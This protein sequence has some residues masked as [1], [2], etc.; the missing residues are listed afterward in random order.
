MNETTRSP[1]LFSIITAV[2]NTAPYLSEAVE[3]IV[4]QDIGFEKS[5]EL[6]LI[7]DGSTDHSGAICDA[8]KEKYPNNIKVVHKKNEGAASARNTGI[9]LA[10]GQYVNF[11]D[12]DD[13]LS[14]DTLSEVYRYFSK[15]DNEID[16]VSVPIYF[17][18]KKDIP[19]R[20]NYKYN[21]SQNLM[22][23]LWKQ[24]SYVQMHASSSFF[25]RE[26]LT[27]D[28]FDSSLRYAEDAKA[29]M[30]LLLQKSR[31][32]IVPRGRYF[33]RF[34]NAMDS[35]LNGSKQHK[36]WYI[37]CLKHFILWTIQE[38]KQAFGFIPKFVQYTL[39]YD[40]QSRFRMEEL[41]AGVLNPKEE[42][43]FLSLLNEALFY[44][45]DHIILEQKNL[46]KE[47][48]DYIIGI[49]HASGTGIFEYFNEDARIRYKDTVTFSLS[50]YV[51]KLQSLDFRDG[52]V[53]IC[54]SVKLN[55]KFPAPEK[56]YVRMISDRN[57]NI[58][59]FLCSCENKPEKR[60]CFL[61]TELA[62]FKNFQVT[63]PLQNMTGTT[64]AEF[65]MTCNSHTIL[66][67]N[68]VA[69]ESFPLPENKKQIYF[70]EQHLLL[71]KTQQ[72][73]LLEKTGTK[74]HAV[75]QSRNY[76]DKIKAIFSLTG[77]STK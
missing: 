66:F 61:G 39:M 73:L 46:S 8:Y 22:V 20:L 7:D 34:R 15:V 38:S 71:K 37:D 60:F 23:D 45:D 11:M 69:S 10:S 41:P 76:R 57:D 12:S 19:H 4:C 64:K 59:T 55:S 13:K 62:Q 27:P 68:L 75:L 1:Y 74:K 47:Q 3:S 72:H 48:K 63:I 5:V 24:Y 6:I 56:L 33:Y 36:E 70:P 65:C 40:L 16:F 28:F 18:E 67:R 25:K 44:I 49:K 42:K 9:S 50:S 52:Q 32:G 30:K 35:A 14:S 31:Y 26:V 77:L 51:L 58:D 17:F 21:T 2:Y 29:I 43:E 54:G 53:H